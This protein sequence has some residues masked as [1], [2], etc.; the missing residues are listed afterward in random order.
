[1]ENSEVN[2]IFYYE[3]NCCSKKFSS[4]QSLTNHINL[5]YEGCRNTIQE[6]PFKCALCGG[7]FTEGHPLRKHVIE[8]HEGHKDLRC[9]KCHTTFATK[10]S[11]KYHNKRKVI[12]TRVHLISCAL[13]HLTHQQLLARIFYSQDSV[14][15]CF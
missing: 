2:E 13:K 5:G 1:M 14:R 15:Y 11:F 4:L 7:Q 8:V 12:I 10:T 3:C 6:C 9:D